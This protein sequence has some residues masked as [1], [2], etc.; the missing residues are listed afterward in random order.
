MPGMH[1]VYICYMIFS[2]V[3]I[4]TIS[5]PSNRAS[6]GEHN[7]NTVNTLARD[8]QSANS[9]SSILTWEKLR[10]RL[11]NTTIKTLP[12]GMRR[13]VWKVWFNLANALR[14]GKHVHPSN[15]IYQQLCGGSDPAGNNTTPSQRIPLDALPLFGAW[16]SCMSWGG[17]SMQKKHW[18][19]AAVAFALGCVNV[20]VD[21]DVATAL[22]VCYSAKQQ[23]HKLQTMFEKLTNGNGQQ[24]THLKTIPIVNNTACQISCTR[25]GRSRFNDT[26]HVV[27]KIRCSKT[28]PLCSISEC[29]TRCD[30]TC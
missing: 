23:L 15:V 22:N 8:I 9:S 12:P 29:E 27:L 7:V 2:F 19:N 11:M 1:Y 5:T 3:T 16:R 17:G 25:M 14:S 26:F 30:T 18:S 24:H 6:I 21:T 28:Q 10:S 13:E 20:A 4:T